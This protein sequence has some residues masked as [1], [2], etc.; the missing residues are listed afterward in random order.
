MQ[1]ILHFFTTLQPLSSH[2]F[3]FCAF[4]DQIKSNY[5]AIY[6]IR[7][8]L[9]HTYSSTTMVT[10]IIFL[11]IL[12]CVMLTCLNKKIYDVVQMKIN[13]MTGRGG[14]RGSKLER[15]ADKMREILPKI[16][17]LSLLYLVCVLC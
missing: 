3:I 12:P 2:F 5:F 4:A 7:L 13:N 8:R 10:T 11:N 9:S 15:Q 14:N 6:Y 1:Q 16:G 17:W